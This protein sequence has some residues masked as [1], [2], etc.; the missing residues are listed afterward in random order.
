MLTV[1]HSLELTWRD[2][3]GDCVQDATSNACKDWQQAGTVDFAVKFAGMHLTLLANMATW[4]ASSVR[5]SALLQTRMKVVGQRY[6]PLLFSSFYAY[7]DYRVAAVQIYSGKHK[8]TPQ[9]GRCQASSLVF[10]Y[11]IE[12]VDTLVETDSTTP[13]CLKNLEGTCLFEDYACAACSN[14]CDEAGYFVL[15]G[16]RAEAERVRDERR[17]AIEFGTGNPSGKAS[18]ADTLEQITILAMDR[19]SGPW[20]PAMSTTT[21]TTN[22]FGEPASEVPSIHEGV[23][24]HGDD[25]FSEAACPAGTSL[26]DCESVP[27]N[28]GDCIQVES[29]KCIARGAAAPSNRR[30]SRRRARHSIQAIASCSSATT[31]VVVSS[32][33]YLDNQEV[34]AECESGNVLNCYC[35]SAWSSSV[36]GGTTEFAPT[37]SSCKKTIGASSGRRRMAGGGAGAKVYALCGAGRRLN[38]VAHFNQSI[39][40]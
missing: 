24:C 9:H 23:A 34:S 19:G 21:T 14:F 38:S 40:V 16:V 30:R 35:Y 20:G 26:I 22:P 1:Q 37:G 28:S 27:A 25:C 11:W 6:A 4:N 2:V 17:A 39:L 7:R 5:M 36:C 33:I 31:S 8:T 32:S 12:V 3:F 10:Y 18:L 29:G 15:T 13:T